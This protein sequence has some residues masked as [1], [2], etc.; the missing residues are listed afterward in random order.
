LH[1]NDLTYSRSIA[2]LNHNPWLQNSVR[3][4]VFYV[5]FSKLKKPVVFLKEMTCQK[6]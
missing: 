6:T 3:E 4:Y 5:F 1:T 2:G